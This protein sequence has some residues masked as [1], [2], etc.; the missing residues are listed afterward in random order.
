LRHTVYVGLREEKLADQVWR[1]LNYACAL[2]G[3]DPKTG[4][5][6]RHEAI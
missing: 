2:F 5:M 4:L 1:R 6:A 3:L